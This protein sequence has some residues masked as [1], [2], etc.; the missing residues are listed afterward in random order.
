MGHCCGS[1]ISNSW[2]HLL[3][4]L[5]PFRNEKLPLADTQSYEVIVIDRT[6]PGLRWTCGSEDP[7]FS[8]VKNLYPMAPKEPQARFNNTP[9]EG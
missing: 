4:F 9:P 7:S 1:A 8:Q 5:Q 2:T 3:F 6:L